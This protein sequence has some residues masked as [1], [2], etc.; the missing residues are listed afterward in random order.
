MLSL[1]SFTADR[2]APAT[3][4]AFYLVIWDLL[5]EEGIQTAD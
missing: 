1:G 2:K 5:R 3:A 4:G